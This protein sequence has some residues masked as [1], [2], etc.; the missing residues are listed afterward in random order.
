EEDGAELELGY[1]EE[2][3]SARVA[4]VDRTFVAD[5]R[6][7]IVDYKL[8][9][10]G[11]GESLAEFLARQQ[12]LYAAQ[13]GRYAALFPRHGGQ[14]VQTALYFPLLPHLEIC[15]QPQGTPAT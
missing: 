3:G 1:R 14:P 10:P 12:E 5:G 4:I 15:S 7:W 8:A 9:E 11:A 13:L 6:R 2:T